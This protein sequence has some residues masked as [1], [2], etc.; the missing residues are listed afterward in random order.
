M[1]FKHLF[2]LHALLIYFI[3]ITSACYGSGIE[4]KDVVDREDLN[5]TFDAF[6]NQHVGQN[7]STNDNVSQ[8]QKEI[9]GCRRKQLVT[10][11]L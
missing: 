3:G 8:I 11:E 10:N 4:I 1:S 7:F 5:R 9:K 2:I 6:C